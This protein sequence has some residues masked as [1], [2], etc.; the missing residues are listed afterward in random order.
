MGMSWR[1]VD[2]GA[3]GVADQTAALLSSEIYDDGQLEADIT[4]LNTGGAMLVTRAAQDL[5]SFTCVVMDADG[6]LK[7]WEPAG[8]LIKIPTGIRVGESFRFVLHLNGSL[9]TIFLN[10]KEI[11]QFSHMQALRGYI[12]VQ[13]AEGAARFQN[14]NWRTLTE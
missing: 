14:V 7:V 5:S 3:E 6:T 1:E 4:L 10:G 12:G 8:D 11:C 2:N 9:L 13:V